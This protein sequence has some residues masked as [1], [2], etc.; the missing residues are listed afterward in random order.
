[1]QCA[2]GE[3]VNLIEIR[4]PQIASS[5]QINLVLNLTHLWGSTGT[6]RTRA[7]Q[8]IGVQ[9]LDNQYSWVCDLSNVDPIITICTYAKNS[10]LHSA[11][12]GMY[13][14]IYQKM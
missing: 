10:L 1:M 3:I 4:M 8:Y 11:L 9:G 6:D 2:I 12:G 5:P 14:L 7:A 13:T